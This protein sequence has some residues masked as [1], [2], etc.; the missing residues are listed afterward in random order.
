MDPGTESLTNGFWI[1]SKI[2]GTLSEEDFVQFCLEQHDLRIEKNE[3]AEVEIR[4]PAYSKTGRINAEI[5]R[6]LGNWN[7]DKGL[8]SSA[9]FYLDEDR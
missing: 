5:N 4:P 1:R 8:G 9:G 3:K 2:I 7:V 6:Q